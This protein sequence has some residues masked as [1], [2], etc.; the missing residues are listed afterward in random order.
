MMI[1][2]YLVFMVFMAVILALWEIQ[3]EG[4]EGWA[5]NLPAWR[6][7]TGWIVRLFG[8]RPLTGYHVFLSLFMIS[9]AHFPLFF[10]PWTWQLELLLI[11]FIA[12][13][14]LIEDFFWFVFNPHYGIKKFR[15]GE[16][17]WHKTWWGPMPSM[18]YYL[19]IV[20]GLLIYFGKDAIL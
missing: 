12:G 8:G 4:G 2:G 5:A 13:L 3:I 14:G 15:K 1:I 20:T 6:I 19:I 16:I 7:K 10:T 9:F 11:G 17:W 18:Y